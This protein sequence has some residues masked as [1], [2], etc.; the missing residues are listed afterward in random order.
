LALSS[1]EQVARMLI[2]L[3]VDGKQSLLG[4]RMRFD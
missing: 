4:R 2:G 3:L 1:R